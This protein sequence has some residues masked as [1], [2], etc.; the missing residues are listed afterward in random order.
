MAEA[1]LVNLAKF[2]QNP[3]RG[4][5]T[6]VNAAGTLNAPTVANLQKLFTVPAGGCIMSKL[7][8]IPKATVSASFGLLLYESTDGVNFTLADSVTMP[9]QVVSTAGGVAKT[10]FGDYAENAPERLEAGLQ[11]W[12]GITVAQPSGIDFKGSFTDFITGT[13]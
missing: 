5:A 12:V 6:V 2:G 1:Q 10:Y 9:A 7:T 8:A 11:L 4:R 13:T 3:R